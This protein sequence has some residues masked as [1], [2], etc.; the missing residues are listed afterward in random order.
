[1]LNKAIVIAAEAHAGQLDKGG[2]PYI[3]HPLRVMMNCEDETEMIC[4]VLHIEAVL[5][6]A[7]LN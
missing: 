6:E 4:A 5:G 1:M 2:Q 3:L 7:A